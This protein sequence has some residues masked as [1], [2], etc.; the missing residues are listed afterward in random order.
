[1]SLVVV[2][3]LLYGLSLHMQLF[4]TPFHFALSD[5]HKRHKE[6]ATI[7]LF[8][9]H[10]HSES[11]YCHRSCFFRTMPLISNLTITVFFL[12]SP[13]IEM[14]R[15]F[16]SQKIKAVIKVFRDCHHCTHT[17]THSRHPQRKMNAFHPSVCSKTKVCNHNVGGIVVLC[18]VV[19]G[20]ITC[21][22]HA[23]LAAFSCKIPCLE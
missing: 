2:A 20:L 12:F 23:M 1:M 21:C 10:L 16:P 22:K 18:R 6:T 8:S 4:Y 17:R 13:L 9:L 3:F 15:I 5:V 7:T 14:S 19:D 11:F